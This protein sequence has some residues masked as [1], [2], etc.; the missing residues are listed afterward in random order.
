MSIEQSNPMP[1]VLLVDD[2]EDSRVLYAEY[3]TSIA[4]YRVAEAENGKQAL[5][6]AAALRPKAIVMDMSLPLMDGREAMRSL[7]GDARTSEIPIIALTGYT[8][9]KASDDRASGFQIVLVK[10]CLPEA[11]TRAIASVLQG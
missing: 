6:M 8:D 9:V 5:E 3:L 11:L 2:D 7:R 10:P 4:G 1:L